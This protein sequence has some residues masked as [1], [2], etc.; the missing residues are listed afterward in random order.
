MIAMQT[1]QARLGR[2]TA[3]LPRFPPVAL[4]QM[5]SRVQLW[6]DRQRQRIALAKLDDR[7]RA[8][9]GINPS[10]AAAECRRWN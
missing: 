5:P 8:D 1:D 10:E 6:L 3:F 7:L 9:V 2:F 4:E